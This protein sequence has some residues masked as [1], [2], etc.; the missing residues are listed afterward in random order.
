MRW[1]TELCRM[2]WRKGQGTTRMEKSYHNAPA[3]EMKQAG[4]PDR[5][6]GRS[7]S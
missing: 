5:T 6:T 3:E 7:V 4:M 1:M 2:V